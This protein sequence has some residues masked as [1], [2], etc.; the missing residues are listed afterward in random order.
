[1]NLH[2]NVHHVTKVTVTA[3]QLKNCY[4]G[5]YQIQYVVIRTADGGEITLDLFLED[6]Q[7]QPSPK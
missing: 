1:M 2:T 5:P 7:S 6:E 3:P 4:A